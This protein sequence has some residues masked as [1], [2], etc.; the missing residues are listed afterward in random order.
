MIALM[1]NSK[2]VPYWYNNVGH[3]FCELPKCE[4]REIR[5]GIQGWY[6]LYEKTQRCTNEILSLY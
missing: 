5:T 6:I 3:S 1:L 4:E 2:Y